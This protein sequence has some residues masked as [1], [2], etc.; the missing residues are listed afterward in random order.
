VQEAPEVD[1]FKK[2]KGDN[3]RTA[4]DGALMLREA[5]TAA[6]AQVDAQRSSVKLSPVDPCLKV[7]KMTH[8]E[9]VLNRLVVRI[10]VYGPT[11]RGN[12]K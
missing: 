5:S 4:F 2:V 12:A 6:T 3:T 9:A 10:T 1:C 8:G 11:A 7:P